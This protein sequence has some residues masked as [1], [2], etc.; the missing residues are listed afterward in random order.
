MKLEISGLTLNFIIFVKPVKYFK[1]EKLN[2]EENYD[3]KIS[4]GFPF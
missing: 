1:V 2:T 3:Q 4:S